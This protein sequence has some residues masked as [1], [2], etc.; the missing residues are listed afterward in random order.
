MRTMRILAVDASTE[1]CAVALGDG[2]HWDERSVVAGQR[3]SELMLPMIRALLDESEAA[4]AGL[5]GIAFGA[6][7]GSFTGLRIACGIAQ[8]LALGAGLRVLGVSTLEALAE[9]A[10]Q[11]DG[12]TRVIAALDARMH[13]V[14]VA[15]YRHDGAAWREAIAPA[16]VAPAAAPLPEGGGWTG[17]GS[18]FA[19]YPGLRE[20]YAPSLGSCEPAL[21]PTAT[22]IGTLALPRLAAGEGVAA[23]DAAPLYVRHKVALTSA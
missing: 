22:A 20:R 3:H 9:T 14:Y 18:G 1:T 6:G 17:V 13:E 5:D 10:R 4:L 19:A 8:G 21:A 15:A 2:V 12:A 7:P 11:R 16:V 23:R